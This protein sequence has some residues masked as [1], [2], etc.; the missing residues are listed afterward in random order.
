MATNDFNKEERVAFEDVLEGFED[1]LVHSRNVRTYNRDKTSMERSSETIWRPQPYIAQ[2]F[3]GTD[4]T[5]NYQGFTQLSVPATIGYESCSPWIMT[6]TE[7]NDALQEGRLGQAAKQKVA[8]DINVALMNIA[9][10]QGTLFVKRSSTA[11]GFADL[12]E[13]DA[14]FNEQGIGMYDRV[15]NLS[16]RDY[17]SMA[18]DLAARETMQGKP[19]TAYEKSYVGMVAGFETYKLDYAYRLSAASTADTTDTQTASAKYYTPVA[20]RTA[21]TGETSNVDN[22]YQT[23][24]ISSTTNVEAG[25]AFTIAGVYAVHHIT[26]Q[27]TGQLKTFRV[28][29]IDSSTTMTISPPVISNQGGTDA[30]AQYQNCTIAVGDESA[31]AAVTYLNT[32]ANYVNPFWHKDAFELLPSSYSV[33]TDAG[34][35]VMKG[36]TDQGIELVMQKFYDIDTMKTKYRLDT[37]WG[38]CCVQPEM[39]GIMMFSQT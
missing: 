7:L 8:S 26:K 10:L 16:S 27:S 21:S 29:S 20:K 23:F 3:S 12:A 11:A 9:A 19:T 39:A 22:R 13:C 28:I 4:M 5:S 1:A 14:V 37:R 6:A 36:S 15:A 34:A 31:T 25:D 33:P 35:A 2:T 32:V 38:V 24:T 30:E 18:A 17:N